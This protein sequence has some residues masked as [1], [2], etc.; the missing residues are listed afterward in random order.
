MDSIRHCVAKLGYTIINKK[1]A[2]K[3][4]SDA[5]AELEVI[6]RVCAKDKTKLFVF[7][8]KDDIAKI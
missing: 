3:A 5:Y 4:M 6:G 8:D 1:I 2:S 7:S